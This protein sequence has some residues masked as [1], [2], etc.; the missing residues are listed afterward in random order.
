VSKAGVPMK[1]QPQTEYVPRRSPDALPPLKRVPGIGKN[2]LYDA[3]SGRYV[4]Y[5]RTS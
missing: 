5:R 4:V 2:V 1:K 3:Y